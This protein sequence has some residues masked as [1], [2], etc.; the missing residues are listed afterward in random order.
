MYNMYLGIYIA[1]LKINQILDLE[2][3]RRM[4]QDFLREQDVERARLETGWLEWERLEWRQA[5]GYE[6]NEE[7]RAR[8]CL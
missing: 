1:Y 7:Q 4:M 8:E 3:K 6:W 5:G 2:R